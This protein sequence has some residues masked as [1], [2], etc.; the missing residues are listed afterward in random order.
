MKVLVLISIV[1]AH[2]S[3]SYGS[4]GPEGA[5]A[6]A[7]VD[8]A[9]NRFRRFLPPLPPLAPLRPLPRLRPFRLPFM[10]PWLPP[11]PP[12]PPLAPLRDI[13][14]NIENQQRA[15]FE[16]AQSSFD[17]FNFIPYIPNFDYRFQ[18]YDHFNYFGSRGGG[19][20][21]MSGRNSAFAAATL[22]PG[23]RHQVAAINPANPRMP[24]VD[25]SSQYPQNSNGPG[26]DFYSVSSSSYASSVNDNGQLKSQRGAETVVN[27]RG[28]VT[29]YSVHS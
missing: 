20:F 22:G 7:Y 13:L 18:P 11:L 3:W 8:T 27:D 14:G 21:G 24:N 1:L 25:T 29:K 17:A 6:F 28:H 9:G 16:A 26:N 19:Q 4:S 12:L 23:Y 2:C 10:F 5:S 15:A